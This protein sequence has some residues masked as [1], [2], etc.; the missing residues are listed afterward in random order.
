M[1]GGRI[2]KGAFLALLLA[3]Q[4]TLAQVDQCADAC[5]AYNELLDSCQHDADQNDVWLSCV[6]ND[7]TFQSSVRPP[8]LIRNEGD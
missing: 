4:L 1:P 2:R 3:G 8:N 5:S 6:C 7:S